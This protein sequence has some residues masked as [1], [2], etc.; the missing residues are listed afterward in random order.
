MSTSLFLIMIVTIIFM[1][2][3]ILIAIIKNKQ[4]SRMNPNPRQDKRALENKQKYLDRYRQRIRNLSIISLVIGL[5]IPFGIFWSLVSE[6]RSM[7]YLDNETVNSRMHDA[8]LLLAVLVGVFLIAAA[9]FIWQFTAVYQKIKPII[10]SLSTWDFEEFVRIN[11]DLYFYRKYMPYFIFSED[12]IYFPKGYHWEKVRLSEIQQ[13]TNEGKVLL[14]KAGTYHHSI[15]EYRNQKWRFSIK[16]AELH[17]YLVGR[18]IANVNK[19]EN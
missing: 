11:Q 4:S 17:N 5:A 14:G 18:I 12:S 2:L 7:T 19:I 1:L 13:F 10:L 3:V 8:Y 16:E 9:V 6:T 15:I